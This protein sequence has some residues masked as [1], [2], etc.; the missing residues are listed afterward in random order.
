MKLQHWFW[1]RVAEVAILCGDDQLKYDCLMETASFRLS[2]F[3]LRMF[4]N[5]SK[6]EGE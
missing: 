5:P 2:A 3:M 4:D 1:Y 6:W